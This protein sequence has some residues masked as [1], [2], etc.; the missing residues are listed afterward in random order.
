[1]VQT[2]TNCFLKCDRCCQ[3][4]GD[5]ICSQPQVT[6][7]G[8][9]QLLRWSFRPT[10]KVCKSFIYL[11]SKGNQNNFFSKESCETA[12]R[13]KN[14]KYIPNAESVTSRFPKM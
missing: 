1:L 8:E 10:I 3:I 4:L 9:S 14:I 13:R 11:G 2:E 7:V 12:C 6:G 5:E